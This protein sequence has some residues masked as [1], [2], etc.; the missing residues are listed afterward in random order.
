[1]I[2]NMKNIELTFKLLNKVNGRDINPLDFIYHHLKLRIEPL[3][4]CS[5]EFQ[6]LAK[7]VKNSHAKMHDGF[8]LI[9]ENIF[10]VA[11]DDQANS[12]EPFAQKPN[13]QLLFHG[14][15]RENYVRILSKGLE[16][17]PPEASPT[18]SMFG[19][20]VYFADMISKSANYC[21]AYATNNTGLVLLCQV[22]LGKTQGCY[23]GNPN[24]KLDEGYDSVKG[25]CKT[26][27]NPDESHIREDGGKI[28]LGRPIVESTIA[29]QLF[30]H[31]YIVYDVAQVKIEYILELKFIF[32]KIPS[33]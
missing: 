3:I 32:K 10:K 4:H 11:R 21:R 2:E 6:L 23:E 28:P 26:Y 1:M 14:S 24:I 22:A 12:F 33:Q 30:H 16:I 27:P 20:G 29:S 19:R 17:A 13:R 9:V 18:G 31:E 7:Y 5:E 8:E 25:I 15:R